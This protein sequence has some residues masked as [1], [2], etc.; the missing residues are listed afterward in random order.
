[1]LGFVDSLALEFHISGESK[2]FC[3]R[4]FSEIL[5]LVIASLLRELLQ[6]QQGIFTYLLLNINI[7]NDII[8]WNIFVSD[9]PLP[10]TKDVQEFIKDLFLNG[11]T[12]LQSGVLQEKSD[13]DDK[14][15][16]LS[17][18]NKFKI[19]VLANAACVDLLVW[20][21]RDEAGKL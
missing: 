20:A 19:N 15:S 6:Y 4:S 2:T 7:L 16:H 13:R 3:Y 5:N 18:I 8:T 9:L 12:E 1:V 11:Q 17:T 21:T 10:F 14:E